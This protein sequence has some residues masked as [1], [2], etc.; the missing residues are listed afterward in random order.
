MPTSRR[1]ARVSLH[2]E[3]QAKAGGPF[4]FMEVILSRG[5]TAKIDFDDMSIVG[6]FFGKWHI[7]QHGEIFY[8]KLRTGTKTVYMHR[9]IMSHVL[10]RK[11]EGRNIFEY[12]AI[13]EGMVIDHINGDGLDNRRYNLRITTHA[14]NMKNTK[15]HRDGYFIRERK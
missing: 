8:A 9:L 7:E 1:R 2:T 4:S 6:E 12:I 5:K 15:R 10:I 14:E 13:P 3:R 11:N